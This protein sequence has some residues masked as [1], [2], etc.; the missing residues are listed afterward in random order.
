MLEQPIEL[1]PDLEWMLLSGQADEGSLVAGLVREYYP[2]LYQLN[3]ALLQDRKAAENCAVQTLVRSVLESHH[4]SGRGALNTWIFSLAL[5]CIHKEKVSKARRRADREWG[6]AELISDTGKGRSQGG[7]TYL[8]WLAVDQLDFSERIILMMETL[9]K[10]STG[11]LAHILHK[12][13]AVVKEQLKRV[14]QQLKTSTSM[15]ESNIPYDSGRTDVVQVSQLFHKHWPLED[16]PER[17]LDRLCR[18]LASSLRATRGKNRRLNRTRELLVVIV[19]IALVMGGISTANRLFSDNQYFIRNEATAT[20][21]HSYLQRFRQMGDAYQISEDAYVSRSLSTPVTPVAALAPLTNQSNS[22]T[23]RER[24]ELSST[25]WN[26]VW[27]EG[28][29]VFYGP[30]GYRGAPLIRRYQ[31]WVSRDVAGMVLSG[32][33]DGQPDNL[34]ILF[35]TLVDDETITGEVMS[36]EIGREFHWSGLAGMFGEIAEVTSN[37]AI[38]NRLDP[39]TRFEV[40]KVDWLAKREVIIVDQINAEGRREA[41]LWIDTIRGKILREQHYMGEKYQVLLREAI[42]SRIYFDVDFPD[43]LFLQWE[44][45]RRYPPIAKSAPYSDLLSWSSFEKQPI[46]IPDIRPLSVKIA[47]P[48]RFDPSNSRLTFQWVGR[49]KA[50]GM[51]L[52]TTELYAGG[53]YLGDV[54]ITHPMGVLHCQRS[55]DGMLIVLL[56]TTSGKRVTEPVRWFRLMQ[57]DEVHTSLSVSVVRSFSIAPDSQRLAI[58]GMGTP[59]PKEFKSTRGIFI[60]DTV[61]GERLHEI[62]ADLDVLVGWSLDGEYVAGIK[63]HGPREDFSQPIS[64]LA[65]K[66]ETGEMVEGRCLS[67]GFSMEA[68]QV[69]MFEFTDLDWKGEINL[70]ARGLE[71]CINP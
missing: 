2:R 71:G 24:I 31:Q 29:V 50:E 33:I 42:V 5:S 43:N 14:Y 63:F 60:L 35:N 16:L 36:N 38:K 27:E 26:T 3:L 22:E 1:S 47:A 8:L 66:V 46:E 55:R 30:V 9:C 34:S 11:D 65:F 57:P 32:P 52:G 17:E 20:A 7:D 23:I 45:T 6:E 51:D 41:R 49:F 54:D 56:E 28:R 19:V 68:G 64:L 37:N 53:Y 4:Y 59:I 67:R 21:Y 10:L 15:E 44:G 61:T 40:V 69:I 70:R 18:R 62:E 39:R 12:P 13:E 25:L 48:E 58:F